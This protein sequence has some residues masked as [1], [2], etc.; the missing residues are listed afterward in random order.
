MP[1]LWIFDHTL[2]CFLC[3]SAHF[4]L[5]RSVSKRHLIPLRPT[6]TSFILSFYLTMPTASLSDPVQNTAPDGVLS[7]CCCSLTL[8]LTTSMGIWYD[9][10]VTKGMTSLA[11]HRVY[12]MMRVPRNLDFLFYFCSVFASF[13]YWFLFLASRVRSHHSPSLIRIKLL[14]LQFVFDSYPWAFPLSSRWKFR[15]PGD[16]SWSRQKTSIV[17]QSVIKISW[18]S[19]HPIYLLR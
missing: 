14:S 19:H 13:S 12:G 6:S 11:A 18:H 9:A 4:C 16:F 2:F 5:S 17:Y 10:G 7:S 15:L 8:T 1:L 3:S